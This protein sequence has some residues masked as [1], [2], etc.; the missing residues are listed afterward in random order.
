MSGF[1]GFDSALPERRDQPP[2]QQQGRQQQQPF[3]G[4]QASNL[5]QTFGNNQGEDEDL[6]V[7]TWGQGGSLMEGGDELNDE[8]FGD[9]GDVG[10]SCAG[11]YLSVLLKL[12]ELMIKVTT[13]NS[14]L[15][16]LNLNP[17]RRKLHPHNHGISPKLRTIP[18]RPQKTISTQL[19]RLRRVS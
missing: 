19:D 11:I 9:F 7:Y 15:N 6:A 12:G 2:H 13:F 16:P 14:R 5:D 3:S 8:T 18:L 4:F 17:R 10:K 1:F